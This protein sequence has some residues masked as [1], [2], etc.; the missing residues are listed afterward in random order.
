MQFSCCRTHHSSAWKW[1]AAA[2]LS[3]L[4]SPSLNGATR[5]CFLPGMEEDGD[6]IKEAAKLFGTAQTSISSSINF[7]TRYVFRRLLE[8]DGVV[9]WQ[10]VG[11]TECMKKGGNAK[12]LMV[13]GGAS[14]GKRCPSTISTSSRLCFSL[15]PIFS[16]NWWAAGIFL[17]RGEFWYEYG[18]IIPILTSSG[19]DPSRTEEARGMTS[20]DQNND[21][22]SS[23]PSYCDCL[24]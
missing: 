24:S 7:A 16:H 4:E 5:M 11:K 10:G 12:G 15:L 18:S 2:T 21:C 1:G 6:S 13:V 19:Y 14:R 3:P 9:L 17:W 20:V 8:R 23:L 22:G